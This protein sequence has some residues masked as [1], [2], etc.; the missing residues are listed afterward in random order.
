MKIQISRSFTLAL[1]MAR[2]GIG[3]F[4]R[5]RSFLLEQLNIR[6][7]FKG[8]PDL[9]NIYIDGF[10]VGPSGQ[11]PFRAICDLERSEKKRN[12]WLPMRVDLS[13]DPSRNVRSDPES[14]I[15]CYFANP[16]QNSFV[17]SY[18]SRTLLHP[19][20]FEPQEV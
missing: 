14:I 15:F 5:E 1:E 19:S 11:Q 20:H 12:K 8:H 3:N 13:L 10:I 16:S 9:R 7:G 6:E 4:L 18:T 2:A 17:F